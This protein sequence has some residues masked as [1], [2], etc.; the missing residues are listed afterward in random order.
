MDKDETAL[1]SLLMY[2][3]GLMVQINGTTLKPPPTIKFATFENVYLHSPLTLN[4]LCEVRRATEP[5]KLPNRALDFDGGRTSAE[6]CKYSGSKQQSH[7]GQ[8]KDKSWQ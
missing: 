1:A 5:A 6:A 3:L 4:R 8:V 7:S 2:I